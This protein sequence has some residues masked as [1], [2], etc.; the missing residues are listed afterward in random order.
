MRVVSAERISVK[1][2]YN[3]AFLL[4]FYTY[5]FERDIKQITSNDNMVEVI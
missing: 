1:I 2:S 3:L 5:K 4:F